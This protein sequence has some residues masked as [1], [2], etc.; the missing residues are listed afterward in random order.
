MLRS[1]RYLSAD[2]DRPGVAAAGQ[3][4]MKPQPVVTS[5]FFP[6]ALA[7]A[8]ISLAIL[9]L[10]GGGTSARPSG[11]S[12][13]LR[14]VAGDVVAA[15]K[16]PLRPAAK[17][18][19]TTVVQHATRVVTTPARKQPAART[20]SAGPA[21][22]QAHRPVHRGPAGHTRPLAH[23]PRPTQTAAP[24]APTSA[25]HGNGKGVGHRNGKGKALGL[26]PKTAQSPTVPGRARGHGR[27]NGHDAASHGNSAHA[28]NGPPAVP[29]GHAYG[30]GGSTPGLPHGHG[31]GK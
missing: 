3:P 16:A 25:V 19:P 30:K 17:A 22:V 24:P 21:R 7:V 12:P 15:V 28:R 14:L 29:P 13:A 4:R 18:K 11:L 1:P 31:G 27:A 6:T 26:L 5:A 20:S 2:F 9:L 10:P 8:S 23:A